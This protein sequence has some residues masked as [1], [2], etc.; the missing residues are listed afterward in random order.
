MRNN[1]V[2][3]VC[4]TVLAL[5]FGSVLVAAPLGNTSDPAPLAARLETMRSASVAPA[6]AAAV[7]RN[8]G[9]I[10]ALGV[11]GTRTLA[12]SDPAHVEDLFHL[13]SAAKPMSADVIATVVAS[14]ELR[15]ESTIA[16][17]LPELMDGAN[18]AYRNVTLRQL[19]TMTGGIPSYTDMSDQDFD[20]L[21]SLA[22]DPQQVREAFVREVLARQPEVAAGTTRHYSNASYSIAALMAE[23]ATRTPWNE[24]VRAR[25]LA[26]LA[27]NS[28][29]PGWPASEM[30]PRE[31]RGYSGAE[32][33]LI[34]QA[35]DT[36]PVGAWITA[37]GDMSCSIADVARFAALHLRGLSGNPKLLDTAS[38]RLLHTPV[39]GT[40]EGGGFG[41][42]IHELD[43]APGA[44]SH[45]ILGSAGSF[46]ALIVLV[47]ERDV[48]V[49][50]M[51]N[52]GEDSGGKK[53]VLSVARELIEQ[54]ASPKR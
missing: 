41:W 2:N 12:G 29:R 38:F 6:V 31:P 17:V 48:A 44:L 37:A 5:A 42:G 36:K 19:L 53:F 28:C 3:M 9:E 45:T 32:A 47:P 1:M 54:Y 14:G 25:L 50:V 24:L 52:I 40:R 51:T 20:R 46:T 11:A 39:E 23:R 21:Q 34:E 30:Q 10:V 49:V 13:G 35:L 16:Q 26:P 33:K 43:W 18:P 27:L 8:S 7:V 15:W 4:A 22:G